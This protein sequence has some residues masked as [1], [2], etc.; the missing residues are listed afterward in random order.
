MFFLMRVSTE[1][2]R[3]LGFGLV[4]SEGVST[5]L[6][7]CAANPGEVWNGAG[8]KNTRARVAPRTLFKKNKTPF[9]FLPTPGLQLASANAGSFLP[10]YG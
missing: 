7:A 10:S 4:T 5:G 9:S 8:R 3:A 6:A 1:S 2:R